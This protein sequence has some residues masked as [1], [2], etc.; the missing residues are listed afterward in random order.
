M[1]RNRQTNKPSS[2]MTKPSSVI[3][4]EK[5]TIHAPRSREVGTE[6]LRESAGHGQ[7]TRKLRLI[8]FLIQIFV[9]TINSYQLYGS[10]LFSIEVLKSPTRL[11]PFLRLVPASSRPLVLCK[12]KSVLRLVVQE[13][14]EFRWLDLKFSMSPSF[15]FIRFPGLL[16]SR[17]HETS[18]PTV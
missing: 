7:S 12:E 18:D 2:K 17:K 8:L 10:F 1:V 15:P 4:D 11:K 3:I 6:E 14:L 5:R 9:A 13:L 16:L